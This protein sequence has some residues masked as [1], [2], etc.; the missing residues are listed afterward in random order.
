MNMEKFNNPLDKIAALRR[1]AEKRLK[2][3]T[4]F[5]SV[6]PPEHDSKRLL[7]ELEV[8]QIELEMQNAELHQAHEEMEK[9]LE[10]Y[11]DLYDFAPV[12]YFT[13]D[14][15]CVIR[16]VNL[17]GGT[18]LGLERSQLLGRS[19]ESFIVRNARPAFTAF[20][21][22]VIAQ[23][24]KESLELELQLA[25]VH[26]GSLPL[27]VQ[28]EAVVSSTGREY[29]IAAIDI[30]ERRHAELKLHSTIKDLKTFSHSVS[31]D[32]QT[33]LYIINSAA[34]MLFKKYNGI[35]NDE[36][37]KLANIIVKR[38]ISMSNLIDDLLR[39][40]KNSMQELTIKPIDMTVLTT[41]RI[42]SQSCELLNRSIEFRVTEL[43]QAIGDRPMIAQV[44]ENL[45]S[46]AIKFSKNVEKPII[47]VGSVEGGKDNIYFVKDNG[48]GFDMKYIGTIFDAFER[49]HNSDDFEGGGIGLAIVEQIITKHGGRVW[50]DSKEGKGSTFYFS[51]PKP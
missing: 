36:D 46:N 4:K 42:E 34:T 18:L 21:R 19:F 48:I 11:T 20:L 37:T 35:Y 10:R 8:H 33:P 12:G 7:H 16:A 45:L 23:K 17:A 25:P 9:V 47:T 44:I 14:N 30:T 38:T 26:E 22:T 39:F 29:L 6:S 50:A 51:L 28:I 40:S 1:Y 31:H 41:E 49:L 13:L 2:E 43:P 24:E 15:N 27:F 32:L 5:N 3:T